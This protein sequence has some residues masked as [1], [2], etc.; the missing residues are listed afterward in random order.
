MDYMSVKE[1][2]ALWGVSIQ[3]VRRYCKDGEIEGA[4]QENGIWRIP[5]GTEKPGTHPEPEI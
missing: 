5:L 3:M 2:A 1:A 4:V